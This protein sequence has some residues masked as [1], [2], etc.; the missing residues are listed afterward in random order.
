MHVYQTE[1]D[2]L[3]QQFHHVTDKHKV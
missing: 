2:G 1:L 3:L